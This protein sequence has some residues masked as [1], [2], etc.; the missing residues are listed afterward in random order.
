M[1]VSICSVMRCVF[2]FMSAEKVRRTNLL[3]EGLTEV[4]I[5]A[6]R[7]GLPSRKH[8]GDAAQGVAEEVEVRLLE[9]VR[10]IGARRV[11]EMEAHIG[12]EIVDRRGGELGCTAFH[13]LR[14]RD[15]ELAADGYAL[16]L[17]VGG[18]IRWR[19]VS[20]AS[21]LTVIG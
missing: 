12:A 18:P 21:S 5:G 16:S 14:L 3:A 17:E 1:A 9:R 2:V 15:V 6:A 4:L 13:E 20:V 8:G 19:A 7:A 11:E 10:Q